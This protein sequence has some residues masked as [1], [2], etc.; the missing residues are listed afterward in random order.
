MWWQRTKTLTL[1]TLIAVLIWVWAEAESLKGGIATNRV[2]FARATEYAVRVEDPPG[3]DPVQARVRLE[4]STLAIDEAQ[5]FL[6]GQVSLTPGADGVPGAPGGTMSLAEVL[7][8]QRKLSDAGATIV[9]VEPAAMTFSVVKLV[10][11][12]LSVAADLTGIV[13]EG[14][15]TVFPTTVKASSPYSLISPGLHGSTAMAWLS[16]NARA[17][18]REDGRQT[19]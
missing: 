18:L 3:A 19:V 9:S 5:R 16:R 12:D 13:A 1:V 10:T 14:E 17:H 11:R 6:A 7:R 8:N 4:G 2:A 15:A